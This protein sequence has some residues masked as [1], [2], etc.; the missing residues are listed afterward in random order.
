LRDLSQGSGFAPRALLA[1]KDARALARELLAMSQD[2]FS[3]A[4][5]N[6]PM[7]RAKLRGLKGNAAVVLG[8]AGTRDDLEVLTRALDDPESLV[9]EHAVWALERLRAPRS[10]ARAVEGERIG[11]LTLRIDVRPQSVDLLLRGRAR[12]DDRPS[13][14]LP[15]HGVLSLP[16]VLSNSNP[17]SLRRPAGPCS[18]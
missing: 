2:E 10:A 4:F 5:K 7:K 12:V 9:R 8:N 15:F 13:A 11:E 3:A 14:H 1:D 17:G 16:I 6:S 18:T